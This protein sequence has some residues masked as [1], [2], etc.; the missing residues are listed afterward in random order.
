MPHI[1]DGFRHLDREQHPCPFAVKP[2]RHALRWEEMDR[3][4]GL[5]D[6]AD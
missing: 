2:E 4:L 5:A 6:Q 3:C 1:C